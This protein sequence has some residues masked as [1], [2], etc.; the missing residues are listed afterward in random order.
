MKEREFLW[1]VRF[2]S[3]LSN[4]LLIQ[5]LTMC[6]HLYKY[7][8]IWEEKLQTTCVVSV[9]YHKTLWYSLFFG[10][11]CSHPKIVL[12]KKNSFKNSRHT[13]R[14]WKLF[15]F[16]LLFAYSLTLYFLHSTSSHKHELIGWNEIYMIFLLYRK[17]SVEKI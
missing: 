7:I 5:L 17:K 10:C 13:K 11:L 9:S 14:S 15:S 2:Y 8:E 1:V 4:W 16:P 12:I 6:T 3:L